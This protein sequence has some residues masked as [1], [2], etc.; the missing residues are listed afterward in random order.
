M[1]IDWRFLEE[2]CG[3]T[4]ANGPATRRSPAPDAG[5]VIIEAMHG[6][7]DESLC[8]RRLENPCFQHFCGRKFFRNDPLCD[9]SSMTHWRQHIGRKRLNAPLQESLRETW[10]WRFAPMQPGPPFY[11]GQ[12]Q[13]HPD[14]ACI[15][16]R[17]ADHLTLPRHTN[18]YHCGHN[19]Q[20][21]QIYKQASA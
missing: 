11:Q 18:Q 20:K 5:L 2:R 9:R 19:E 1:W 7:Y 21:A 3:A 17:H 13:A 8:D 4:Y 12:L 16:A 15:V 14:M 6:Y 10:Q